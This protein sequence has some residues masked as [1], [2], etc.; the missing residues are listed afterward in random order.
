MLKGVSTFQKVA[1]LLELV[2]C[3][4]NKIEPALSA[5]HTPLI[6]TSAACGSWNDS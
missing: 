2:A 5:D 3:P 1:S 6:E 4:L